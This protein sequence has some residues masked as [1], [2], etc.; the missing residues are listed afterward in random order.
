VVDQEW[1][2]LPRRSSRSTVIASRRRWIA[3]NTP[4]KMNGLPVYRGC[5]G[6]NSAETRVKARSWPRPAIFRQTFPFNVF[7]SRSAGFT[8]VGCLAAKVLPLHLL[9]SGFGFRIS[10]IELCSLGFGFRVPHFGFR[11]PHFGF[12][13]SG[14]GFRVPGS[15]FWDSDFGLRISGF[16]FRI[17]GFGSREPDFGFRG[18]RFR[19]LNQ[20][21][22]FRGLAIQVSP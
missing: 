1:V 14:S 8:G 9:F 15:A 22:V 12:R 10:G 11:A 6:A 13:V 16:G 4:P 21:F 7:S 2:A 20:S 5:C 3:I 18:S 19:G 17:L